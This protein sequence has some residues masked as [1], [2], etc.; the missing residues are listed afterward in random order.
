[1]TEDDVSTPDQPRAQ[2]PRGDG[3]NHRR[4]SYAPTVTRLRRGLPALPT[5][6]RG[7]ARVGA[8]TWRGVLL[9]LER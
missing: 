6:R 4:A 8:D 3:R 9:D 7:R 2:D 5:D 1:M